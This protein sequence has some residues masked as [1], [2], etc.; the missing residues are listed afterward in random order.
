MTGSRRTVAAFASIAGLALVLAACAS[1]TPAGTGATG[2]P[3]T[4]A[5]GVTVKAMSVGILGTALVNGDG[6]TLYTLSADQ[7]GK[8]TCT[9][10]SCTTIWPPLIVPT[11][12]TAVAGSGI[13][14]SMLGT[15]T[16]PSGAK[17]VTYNNW[18]LYMFSHDSG[19]GQAN[20][21]GINSFGGVWHPIAPAG[22]PIVGGPSTA[23]SSSSSGY[24]Y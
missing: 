20:G 9:S 2:S 7:G 10:S 22:Q 3:T 18:P 11:G 14:A 19:A 5:G 15:V 8:V 1:K 6:R 4:G 23:P 21:Q 24:G 12:G 13:T 17:Q 16:T